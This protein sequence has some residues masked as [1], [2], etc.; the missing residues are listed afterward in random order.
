MIHLV[1]ILISYTLNNT[2]LLL[3]SPT[4]E[5]VI[6]LFQISGFIISIISLYI[7]REYLRYSLKNIFFKYIVE[8]KAKLLIRCK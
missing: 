2:S 3:A 1:K 7:C 6:L 5:I 8:Q 4:V